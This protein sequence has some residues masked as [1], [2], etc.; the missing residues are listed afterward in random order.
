MVS[1]K[2]APKRSNTVVVKKC[3]WVVNCGFQIIQEKEEAH[4]P[5]AAITGTEKA[6]PSGD[7]NTVPGA[8]ENKKLF[9][10]FG[11]QWY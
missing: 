10:M 4:S 6:M 8:V 3:G 2:N 7:Q 1:R 11:S 5:Y 9:R